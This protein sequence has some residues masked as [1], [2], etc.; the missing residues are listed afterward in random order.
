VV[1]F[2]NFVYVDIDDPISDHDKG[3]NV[4][5]YGFCPNGGPCSQLGC[6]EF[7]LKEE[8]KEKC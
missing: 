8:G 6:R 7:S 1:H 4:I 3:K 2:E 5:W